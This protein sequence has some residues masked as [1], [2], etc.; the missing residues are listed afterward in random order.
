MRERNYRAFCAQAA[1]VAVVSSW[2][3]DDVL[4][5]YGLAADKVRVV[6]LAPA[7][8]AYAPPA[9]DA[10]DALIAERRLPERFVFYPAQTWPHKNHEALF[11]ALAALR[12]EAG[13]V[14]PL[15]CSGHRNRYHDR[16]QARA[17][18]LGIADQIHFPGFVTAAE[19]QCLYA[20]C[21]AVVIPSL[22]EAAS[23][24]LWEAFLAG[25]PAACSNV[26]SLPA[27]AGDAALV[28]D[29]RDV[30]AIATAVARLW[31]DPRLR[32]DLVQR[33]RANVARFSWGHTARMFR[34]HYRRIAGRR[35]DAADADLLSAP[36]LL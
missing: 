34:A 8:Q 12:V 33:G 17:A 16:L 2:T 30:R 10:T 27:Q 13:L 23:F 25:A 22:F 19:L 20:R 32:A 6:P 3:R 26:T 14:V 29:P 7:T 24:P 21:E 18:A 35:L 1:M 4:A 31:T 5:Q 9:P 11:E 15:V 28:F 36:P